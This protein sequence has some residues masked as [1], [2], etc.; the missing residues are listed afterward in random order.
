MQT[1]LLPTLDHVWHTTPH[2]ASTY[3]MHKLL[4][5]LP[6]LVTGPNPCFEA[7]VHTM[8]SLSMSGTYNIGALVSN[9]F[10]SA[11]EKTHSLVHL[12]RIPFRCKVVMGF[13]ILEALGEL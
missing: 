13:T 10:N 8:K 1:L 7:L 5:H 9:I 11:K 12:Y 3:E 2:E 6:A 4:P